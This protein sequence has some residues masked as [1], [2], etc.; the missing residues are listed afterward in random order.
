MCFKIF[1]KQQDKE[2]YL[3]LP[4][5]PVII[6]NCLLGDYELTQHAV[7]GRKNDYHKEAGF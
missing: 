5:I 7:T 2:N 3:F 4:E 6:T 1:T